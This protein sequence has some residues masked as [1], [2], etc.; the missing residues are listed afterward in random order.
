MRILTS[1]LLLFAL[2]FGFLTSGIVAQDKSYPN[3]WT[4]DLDSRRKPVPEVDTDLRKVELPDD[5]A[6]TLGP[7][8]KLTLKQLTSQFRRSSTPRTVN[9]SGPTSSEARERYKRKELLGRLVNRSATIILGKVTSK[10]ATQIANTKSRIEATITILETLKG[11][12][13]D[14]EIKVTWTDVTATEAPHP[15]VDKEYFT[16]DGIWFIIKAPEA[17]VLGQPVEWMPSEML[18]SVTEIIKNSVP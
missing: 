6:L 8:V 3:S 1:I 13:V 4:H 12:T 10:T 15:S 18:E 7:P 14:K 11:T 16:E 5:R 17:R 2:L 9:G